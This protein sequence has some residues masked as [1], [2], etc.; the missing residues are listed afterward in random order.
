MALALP[1]VA[2]VPADP[3]VCH[4]RLRTSSLSLLRGP[5]CED[6]TGH[7]AHSCRAV[8]TLGAGPVLGLSLAHGDVICAS[9]GHSC[10]MDPLTVVGTSWETGACGHSAVRTLPPENQ[11]EQE[12]GWLLLGTVDETARETAP[13][14]FQPAKSVRARSSWEGSYCA[15]KE[16]VSGQ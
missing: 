8:C 6:D 10:G 1:S 7:P 16:V 11:Q 4:H 14:C 12:N 5:I 9:H 3:N 15:R 13:E 2:L